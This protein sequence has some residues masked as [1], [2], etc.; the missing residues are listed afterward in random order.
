MLD[1]HDVAKILKLSY[2]TINNMMKDGRL[3]YIKI[4]RTVR[5][6]EDDVDRIVNGE[7]VNGTSR[8]EG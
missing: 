5:F 4:G 6:R 1:K 2:A 3:H 8:A 7:S